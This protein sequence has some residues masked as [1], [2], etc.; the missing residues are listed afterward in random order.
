[1]LID[2]IHM[3]TIGL[4]LDVANHV[5]LIVS[6]LFP[7]VYLVAALQMNQS[8]ANFAFASTLGVIF[9]SCKPMFHA[10]GAMVKLE[11]RV[12]RNQMLS[13]HRL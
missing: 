3:L 4:R 13:D 10:L 9:A 1:M 7:T 8:F 11:L 12:P 6:D 5:L 2:A